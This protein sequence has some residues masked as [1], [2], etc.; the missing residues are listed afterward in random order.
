MSLIFG[1]ILF[2]A[3]FIGMFFFD[4]QSLLS[5]AITMFSFI[6]GGSNFVQGLIYFFINRKKGK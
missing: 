4:N 3:G 5:R 2:F 6:F 1:G